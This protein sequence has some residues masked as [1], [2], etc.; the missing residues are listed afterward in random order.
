MRFAIGGAAVAAALLAVASIALGGPS[1][2]SA[3][4]GGVKTGVVVVNTS[5]ATGGGAAGTW[6]VLTSSGEV[7]TNNHVIRGADAIRVTDVSTGRSYSATVTGYSV[8]KD[9]ALLKLRNASGLRTATLGNSSTV[10]LGDR[11]TAVGNAGG[12]GVLSTKKGKLTGL[13]QSITVSDGEGGASRLSGLIE[14][15]A[16]LRPGDSGGPL[17]RNGNVIGVDAAASASLAFPGGSGEGY[18]IP[19]DTAVG[20]VRQIEAGH[21][22]SVVHVGPTAF[23]GVAVGRPGYYGQSTAGALVQDVVP[24]SPADRAGIGPDDVITSLGG[25]K[26]ASPNQLRN[27]ILRLAPGR[28]VKLVWLD[29]YTGANRATV[30]LVSGPPQ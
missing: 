21:R 15:S 25:K 27:T 22:S 10:A 11:V 24:G 13:R 17:L 19:I 5:L 4:A 14:T 18:A 23:L 9:I 2:A 26:I 30:R 29:Q 20:I 3:A 28:S 1:G 8:S 16:P 6:I 12:T 7:L